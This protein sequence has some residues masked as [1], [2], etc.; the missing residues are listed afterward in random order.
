VVN[1]CVSCEDGY[2]LSKDGT[3]CNEIPKIANCDKQSGRNC[4]KCGAGFVGKKEGFSS[5]QKIGKID[6]CLQQT[7]ELCTKCEKGFTLDPKTRKKCNKAAGKIPSCTRQEGDFCIVCDSGYGL[8]KDKRSC[9][10]LRSG[11]EDFHGGGDPVAA[12]EAAVNARNN[13]SG[14][15]NPELGDS[16]QPSSA[17]GGHSS[18]PPNSFAAQAAKVVDPTIGEKR[19]RRKR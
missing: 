12:A 7:G 16:L 15:G 3:K 10:N 13:L 17:L 1:A 14:R 9:N 19:T 8:S 4:D 18:A 6:N 5:C 2:E 11:E